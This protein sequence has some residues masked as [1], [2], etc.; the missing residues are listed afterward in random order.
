[1]WGVEIAQRY[2]KVSRTQL[3]TDKESQFRLISLKTLEF[4]WNK[5][6]PLQRES[7]C[8]MWCRSS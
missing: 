7:W 8:E 1:M 6:V 3:P 2:N 4:Q 5:E